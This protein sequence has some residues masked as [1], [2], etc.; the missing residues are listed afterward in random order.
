MAQGVSSASENSRE[1]GDQSHRFGSVEKKQ[2]GVPG[3]GNCMSDCLQS[4]QDRRG[5]TNQVVYVKR[6]KI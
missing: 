1:G 5:W 2:G 4:M 3:K 6:R